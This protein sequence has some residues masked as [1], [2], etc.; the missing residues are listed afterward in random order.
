MVGDLME[1]ASFIKGMPKSVRRALKRL[2]ITKQGRA[3]VSDTLEL[4]VFPD[5][6]WYKLDAEGRKPE[7][8]ED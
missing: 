3:E 8:W 7:E 1:W 4:E 6:P 2:L 5:A